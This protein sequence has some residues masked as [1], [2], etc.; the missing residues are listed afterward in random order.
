[1]VQHICLHHSSLSCKC[2]VNYWVFM[3]VISIQQIP[4][5]RAR[6]PKLGR[7]KNTASS[8]MSTEGS[9][10]C[11]SPRTTTTKSKVTE[12]T[13]SNKAGPKNAINK[14]NT[15]TESKTTAL[16]TLKTANNRARVSKAKVGQNEEKAIETTIS[17]SVEQVQTITLQEET[18][19]IDANSV[20][21]PMAASNEV[22]VLG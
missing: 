3:I 1:M 10:T 7:H 19:F 17:D 13:T 14:P 8:E 9:I 15:K 4:P 2:C 5:T 11:S 22:S 6:S 20:S 18:T 12:V 16:K 21:V